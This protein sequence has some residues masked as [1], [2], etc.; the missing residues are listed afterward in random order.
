M[1]LSDNL[2]SFVL[3]FGEMGSRWGI[4]RTV[5]QIL[6]LL[7]IHEE[8][9]NADQ[10]GTALSISRGNVS[11]GLKELQSWRLIKPQ[12]I[13]GDRKDYF[14]AAGDVWTL[15]LTVMEERRKRE[16]DPTIT[17]L[18][19][20]LLKDTNSTKEEY[21]R[22]KIRDI[23]DLLE[24]ITDWSGELQSMEPA[25]LKRLMKLGSG[26]SKVLDV[27]DKFLGKT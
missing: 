17:L 18:R 5:G 25:S 20:L 1:E 11:M 14:I 27:K 8:P 6:A 19:D 10:I 26:V 9:L 2:H 12:H 7:V 24:M 21:A 4:N 13:P 16:V 15:A 3:H 23:H 22:Q